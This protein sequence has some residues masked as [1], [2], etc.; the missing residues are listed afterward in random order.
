M[1]LPSLE[2]MTAWSTEET[3]SEVYSILPANW[4]FRYGTGGPY[5]TASIIDE[6]GGVRWESGF[7]DF[8]MLLFDAYGWLREH[9]HKQDPS[10]PAWETRKRDDFRVPC[11]GK[12][13]LANSPP[14]P[15]PGD[16]DPDEVAMVYG[17]KTNGDE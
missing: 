11:T 9:L 12:V 10:H 1:H 4:K 3:L 2:E 17:I 6:Q 14:V 7:P 16:I 13:G 5:P 8:K 15:E